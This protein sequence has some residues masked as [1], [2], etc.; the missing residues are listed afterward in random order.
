MTED[1]FPQLADDFRPS[2][3]KDGY[4][5]ELYKT[6]ADVFGEER[7]VLSFRG[8]QGVKDGTADVMQAFGGE[9]DQYSRA[10]KTAKALKKA[11]G[12]KLDITGHS[13]G[14]GMA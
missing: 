3:Y 7:Y 9:T 11:V 10:V 13:M 12:D 2:E 5:P 1:F 14:G 6:K 8:T 4:Y